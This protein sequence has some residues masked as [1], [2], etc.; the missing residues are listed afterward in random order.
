VIL[1]VAFFSAAL[2][3]DTTPKS[4]PEAMSSNYNPLIWRGDDAQFAVNIEHSSY[5]TAAFS[6]DVAH[7]STDPDTLSIARQSER[8]NEKVY[9]KLR[10]MGKSLSF[11]FP[12][13]EYIESCP[14]ADKAK[15]LQGSELQ[16]S[17]I[18]YLKQTDDAALQ[19]FDAEID[20][21]EKPYNYG[22]RKFAEQ[23]RPALRDIQS[24]LEKPSSQ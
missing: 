2:A 5:C 15:S 24:K 22:L 9:R 1:L 7:R 17:Y 8:E 10:Q 19:Q 4:E 18:E 20:R 11:E 6:K 16:K 13:K 21:P 12:K 23:E 14:E 3:Q